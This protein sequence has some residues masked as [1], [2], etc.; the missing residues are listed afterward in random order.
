MNTY[1]HFQN[2]YGIPFFP[3]NKFN[4]IEHKTMT[5]VYNHAPMYSRIDA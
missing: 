5:V 4:Q 1:E 3:A 2:L